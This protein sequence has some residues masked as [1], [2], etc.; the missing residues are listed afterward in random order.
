M[1]GEEGGLLDA[2]FLQFYGI[3]ISDLQEGSLVRL[4]GL[5]G[6]LPEDS[7]VFKEK[8][9]GEA[10]DH[11]TT[12]FSRMELWLHTLVWM[13]TEDATKK[14]NQPEMFVAD[15]ISELH[16][17]MKVMEESKKLSEEEKMEISKFPEQVHDFIYGGN[18]N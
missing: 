11:N 13:K 12:L 10:M 6:N 17:K 7:R 8:L 1:H 3:S 14:R 16:K 2:D 4:C 5:A 9:G 18:F 15:H